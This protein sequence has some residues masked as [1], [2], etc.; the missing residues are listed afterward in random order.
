MTL[1][2]EHTSRKVPGM[3]RPIEH[4]RRTVVVG[5]A[6]LLAVVVFGAALAKTKAVTAADLGMDAALSRVHV[7]PVTDLA[8]AI[9]KLFSPPF[10][11]ALTVVVALIIW[12]VSRNWRSAFT[13]SVVVAVSWLSSDVVKILVARPRPSAS[14]LANPFLPTPPDPSFPSGHVVFAA[15]IAISFMFLARQTARLILV[16]VIGVLAALLTGFAVV[17]LGVH[18]PT[19]VLASFVWAAGACPLVL[20]VWNRFVIPRLGPP[21]LATIDR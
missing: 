13:F 5:V 14:A 12:A 11:I 9:Y 7:T 10:A 3:L 4:S 18:Y 21:S 2:P 15:S 16:V 19:D 8:L 20:T 1:S 6:L 17:Y